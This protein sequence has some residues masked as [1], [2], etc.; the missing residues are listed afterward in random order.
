MELVGRGP[1]LASL[2]ERLGARWL[3]TITGPGGIGKTTL[4]H[5]AVEQHVR[6]GHPPAA[7]VDLTRVETG[8][9]LPDAV[10]GQL[11]LP[12]LA[13]VMDGSQVAGR[14]V[15]LDNCEHVLDA[16]AELAASLRDTVGD[17]T[18]L[19]TSRSP[20]DLPGESV[21]ALGPLALPTVDDARVDAPALQVLLARARDAGVDPDGI[22][23]ATAAE[24]CRRL[25]GMPLALELAAARLRSMS[26]EEVLAALQD[27]ASALSRPRFRG[28]R[29]HRS[30]ADMVDWSIALLADEARRGFETLGILA[31]PFTA[32]SAHAVVAE[33]RG[34]PDATR[35]VLDDLVDASLLVADT[36]GMTTW[37]R[38][39]HPVRAVARARLERRGDIDAVQ[40]RHVDHVV[41]VAL[42]A[43]ASSASGWSRDDLS[44]L[45]TTYDD[46]ASAVRWAVAH[47]DAP[48]RAFTLV[49]LLW[50]VVHQAHTAD[51]HALGQQVLTRWPDPSLPGWADAVA[52][53]ATCHYLL[54]DPAG[55]ITMA[56][57]ALADADASVSAFAP[58]TLRR[59][60]GQANRAL[61][62]LEVAHVVF[63]EAAEAAEEL[64]TAGLAME[65]WVD[66]GLLQ[67]EL[68]DVDGG[69]ALIE[70]TLD[71]ARR[72]EAEVNVAWALGCRAAVLLR[73]S[74]EEAL[75]AIDAAL[76][77]SRSIGYPAGVSFCLRLRALA[78][79]QRRDLVAAA[80]TVTELL[81]E[82]TRQGGTT[83][84]RMALDL[85]AHV[86]EATDQACWQDLAVTAAA[87]PVTSIIAPG[88]TDL[89]ARARAQ[90]VVLE[91]RQARRRAHEAM[92][93]V[94]APTGGLFAGDPTSMGAPMA[95]LRRTGDVC[96]F[97]FAGREVAV[98]AGKGVHDLVR[99]LAAPGREIAALDLMGGGVVD[100]V[101][102]DELVDPTAR[103]HYAD[104]V[105]ELQADLEEADALHDLVRAE[106]L[107]I[108]LD[109][110]VDHLTRSTGLG[111]RSRRT[112]TSAERARSAVT[113][114]IRA[115]I[116]RI[117][118]HDPDLGR[119]LEA[120]VS[121]GT[122]CAYHPVPPVT[123]EIDP[124]AGG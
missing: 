110:L 17:V 15:V 115:T 8:E 23:R 41:V 103:R 28:R 59:L 26:A 22:D 13:A 80:G 39:L 52:T 51:V 11:G 5:A 118:E 117:A 40:R 75:P 21:L 29:S 104:R 92:V 121:T 93:T 102:G 62:H 44:H 12:D 88:D 7:M 25:D 86:A 30:V 98:R 2:V 60:L 43:I 79:L 91:V 87:L 14:L 1:E 95:A 89:F 49:A 101:A 69:L 53:V 119:H 45:L 37:Y 112:S 50:G 57:E 76:D 42:G 63:A 38:M 31:G 85:A 68:G 107:R 77:T 78:H 58:V 6:G 32:E 67:A 106:G 116:R 82:L 61:G 34:R 3:V 97:V 73:R 56:Q 74:V 46:V 36:S 33:A 54:G 81:Q 111:G 65:L 120:F 64:G 105:R 24:I 83:D 10:A 35:D 18:I 66:H 109:T 122:W 20:L 124:A 27:D 9:A 96:T 55:A 123:W 108:E 16:A 4:A 84:L 19:A 99:L 72:A 94:A 47:D 114:R 48:D 90:G 113:Q 70:D 100:P 71:R